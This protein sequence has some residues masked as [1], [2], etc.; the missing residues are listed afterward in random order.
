MLM[1]VLYLSLSEFI[2]VQR[3]LFEWNA[4]W[5]R[6]FWMQNVHMLFFHAWMRNDSLK[7]I[8]YLKDS[9]EYLLLI[10]DDSHFVFW[11]EIWRYVANDLASIFYLCSGYF[12]FCWLHHFT[13]HTKMENF[14][15]T[16]GE[17]EGVSST[18]AKINFLFANRPKKN[19]SQTKKN[20]KGQICTEVIFRWGLQ[21]G[22]LRPWTSLS[23]ALLVSHLAET[24]TAIHPWYKQWYLQ[25][26]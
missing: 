17:V 10:I 12:K 18:K 6:K 14:H 22:V 25:L 13:Y 19:S 26:L 9:Y 20:Q 15:A 1:N 24:T 21:E 3:K 2:I 8:Q 16:F 7:R 4:H 11:L 5:L 23:E